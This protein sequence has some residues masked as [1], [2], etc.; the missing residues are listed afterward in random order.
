MTTRRW[1][2]ALA[3]SALFMLAGF[4]LAGCIKVDQTLTLNA[5]GSGT[6]AMRYGMAEETLAQLR[7]MQ[8]MAGPGGEGLSMEQETPFDFDPEEL[9][10]EF[11]ADRPAGVEL[12]ALSSEVVNGWK[13][14]DLEI[15]FDDIRALKRTELFEDSRLAITQLRNGNFRVTQRGSGG[16]DL[17]GDAAGRALMPQMTAMLAGFRIVQSIVVPGE[18]IKTNASRV[19]GRRASWVFDIADD[20]DVMQTL[21]E[22]DLELVLSGEGVSLPAVAP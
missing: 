9:R 10:A 16:A 20:P 4:T 19:D 13:F 15:A 14:I 5:D 7:A 2:R 18:I 8:Q 21:A 12:T 22:T 3:L 6:L 11:E 1:G 17:S